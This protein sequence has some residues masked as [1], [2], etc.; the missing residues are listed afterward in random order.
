MTTHVCLVARALGAEGV[1]IAGQRDDELVRSVQKV[2]KAWGGPF[3]VDFTKKPLA[4]INEWRQGNGK[5]VHLTMYGLPMAEVQGALNV[6]KDLLI[7]IGGE[8]VPFEYYKSADFNVSIGSQPHSEVA[9][10]AIFLDRLT[11][12]SWEGATFKNAKLSITPSSRGK[13]VKQLE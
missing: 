9:A 3:W 10:L 11:A 7:V 1:Y 6:C 13:T 2:V 12:R 5:V 8:K 4:L